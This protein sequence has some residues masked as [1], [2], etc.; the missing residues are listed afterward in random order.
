MKGKTLLGIVSAFDIARA[1]SLK[2]TANGEALKLHIRK[3]KASPWIS[4]DITP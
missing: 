4:N 2:G 3:G 1:V